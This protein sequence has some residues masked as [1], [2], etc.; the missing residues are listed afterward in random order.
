M[1]QL[2]PSP[3]RQPGPSF[4]AQ[5]LIAQPPVPQPTGIVS[6]PPVKKPKR[7]GWPTV[8]ITAAVALVLG[9]ML[10][11]ASDTSSTPGP[12]ATVTKTTTVA[13]SEPTEDPTD[14]SSFHTTKSDWNATLKITDKQCFGSAGCNVDVR[15]KIGY[16]GDS[17]LIPEDATI[18]LTYKIRG[19]SDGAVIGSTTVTNQTEYDVNT[20]SV[21]T[22][23]SSS[24]LS[25]EI[26]DVEV[27]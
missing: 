6:P 13:P 2:P 12:T 14:T 23:S 9:A 10:G 19:A 8:I 4:V 25:V 7:F 17:S 15:V 21:E 3:P 22:R 20:E 18:E 11:G 16:Y 24:K 26:T 1:S 27:Y 5:P